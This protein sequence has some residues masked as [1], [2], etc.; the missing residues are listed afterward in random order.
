MN[1]YKYY[2]KAIKSFSTDKLKSILSTY[3]SSNLEIDDICLSNFNQYLQL[4]QSVREKYENLLEGLHCSKIYLDYLNDVNPERYILWKM[5]MCDEFY[6]GSLREVHQTQSYID[7]YQRQISEMETS[8]CPFEITKNTRD[9]ICSKNN[10]NRINI[11]R[12]ELMSRE[13]EN[14]IER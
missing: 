9:Y 7:E 13:T 11:I 10:I 1:T 6:N 3:E 12:Q 14:Q 5:G 8:E 4:D 2:T